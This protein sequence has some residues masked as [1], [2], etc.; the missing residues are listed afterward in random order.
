MSTLHIRWPVSAGCL[1]RRLRAAGRSRLALARSRSRAV[2]AAVVA[3]P[4][5]A[6]LSLSLAVVVAV[7]VLRHLTEPPSAIGGVPVAEMQ[8]SLTAVS[9]PQART[10]GTEIILVDSAEQAARVQSSLSSDVNALDRSDRS[11]TY[12]QLVIAVGSDDAE[13]IV[14]AIHADAN[15]AGIAGDAPVV[16]TDLRRR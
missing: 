10:G 14:A 6:V 2:R 13:P 12:V 3:G 11:G 9:M 16:I 8:H 5:G 1:V 4:W 7:P 15:L